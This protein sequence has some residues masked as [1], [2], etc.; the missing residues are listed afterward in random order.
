[1]ISKTR[2][3]LY[4]DNVPLVASFWQ[5]FFEAEISETQELPESYLTITLCLNE[6]V[7]LALFPKEFIAKHSPEVLNNTPSLMLFSN[8]FE[9]LHQ[10]IPGA[11]EITYHSGLAS[12]P[13]PDPEGNYFVV[14]KNS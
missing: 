7:E 11:L 13:F 2:I 9:E 8:Q 6:T 10:K 3:M 1:M 14:A 4:V 5:D 12:F